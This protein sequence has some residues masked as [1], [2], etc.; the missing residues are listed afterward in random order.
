MATLAT[1]GW[2]RGQGEG[3]ILNPRG[4][5]SKMRRAQ[6][7]FLLISTKFPIK[8]TRRAASADADLPLLT[9]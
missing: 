2:G 4:F 8:F 9:A 7:G 1:I 5:T 3:G 6:T